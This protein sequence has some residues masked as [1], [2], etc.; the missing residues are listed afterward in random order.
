MAVSL[1]ALPEPDKYR[2]RCSQPTTGLNMWSQMEELEKRLKKLR[3]EQQWQL[4]RP[5]ELP[6]TRPLT[7]E[8]TWRDP[9]FWPYM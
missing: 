2:G 5:P 4:T 1:E 3:E 6:G 7:K 8:Y 9:W